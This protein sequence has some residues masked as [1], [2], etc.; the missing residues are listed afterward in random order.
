MGLAG[1][2]RLRGRLFRGDARAVPF[3]DGSFDAVLNLFSS[4]GYFGEQGDGQ[5]LGEIAR[6]VRPGGQVV[7]ANH[8]M[9]TTGVLGFLEKVSA[10][11]ANTLGWHSDFEMET[12]LQQDA[13]QVEDERALPPMGMMTFLVLRKRG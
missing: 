3:G 5:V 9:R 4:F 12:V 13:L 2:E 10:P 11:F 6:L 7:I 8:F 1:G